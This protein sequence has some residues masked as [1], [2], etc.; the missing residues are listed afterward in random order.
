MSYIKVTLPE[1]YELKERIESD[2]DK[3]IPFY[4]KYGAV[5]GSSDSVEYLTKEIEKYYDNK[6]D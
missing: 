2:K 1:R 6:K 5:M 3:W 4:A